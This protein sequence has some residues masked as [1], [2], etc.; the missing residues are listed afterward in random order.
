MCIAFYIPRF[1]FR[2]GFVSGWFEIF[3]CSYDSTSKSKMFI[4]I[5]NC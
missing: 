3:I 4:T 2:L 5:Y 1:C